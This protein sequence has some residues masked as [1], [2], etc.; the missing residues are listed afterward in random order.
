[1]KYTIHPGVAQAGLEEVDDKFRETINSIDVP[2]LGGHFRQGPERRESGGR[3]VDYHGRPEVCALSHAAEELDR[4]L[5][6][7][8]QALSRDSSPEMIASVLPLLRHIAQ[9]TGNLELEDSGILANDCCKA[10][11]WQEAEDILR[12]LM[13]KCAAKRDFRLASM[14]A[15]NIFD[16]LS[17]RLA[18]L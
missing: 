14:D 9:A 15:G 11:R 10:G 13:P 1:M 12:S 18:G 2:L 5:N 7:V 3:P 8:E 4:G 16:I 6:S 17:Y